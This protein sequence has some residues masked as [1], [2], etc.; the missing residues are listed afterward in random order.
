MCKMC[1]VALLKQLGT[2]VISSFSA[3]L[4]DVVW[5]RPEPVTTCYYLN[6]SIAGNTVKPTDVGR[7]NKINVFN[8]ALKTSISTYK[9]TPVLIMIHIE[10]FTHLL[11]LLTVWLFFCRADVVWCFTSPHNYLQNGTVNIHKQICKCSYYI[12]ELVWTGNFEELRC[13]EL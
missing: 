13:W 1:G 12:W 10:L 5:K 3:R 6:T 9:F 11:C 7:K 8:A 4:T 2:E